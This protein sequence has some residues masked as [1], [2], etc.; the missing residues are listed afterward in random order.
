M[1]RGSVRVRLLSPHIG[2]LTT[3]MLRLLLVSAALIA[4][5]QAA[6]KASASNTI[7]KKK[8]LPYT[9]V[10]NKGK[11]IATKPC[12]WDLTKNNCGACKKGGKQCGFPMHKWCQSPRSKTGCPGIP[13]YK[14]TLSTEGAPCY[15]DPTK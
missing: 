7:I 1:I 8:L 13:N 5:V 3:M 10:D 2:H 12:W 9:K 15:W 6:C 11:P 14:Y 4:V